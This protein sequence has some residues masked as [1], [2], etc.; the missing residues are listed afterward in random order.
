MNRSESR[1]LDGHR[2][3]RC[4]N[5]GNSGESTEYSG[6]RW[7]TTQTFGAI[8]SRVWSWWF[9]IIAFKS[10]KALQSAGSWSNRK[11]VSVHFCRT[12]RHRPL[13]PSTVLPSFF[14]SIHAI[15][16][17][18]DRI[19]VC[20]IAG[21]PA[22]GT[23]G[24]VSQTHEDSASL[25]EICD[26]HLFRIVARMG[27][28]R[29]TSIRLDCLKTKPAN[30]TQYCSS[31]FRHLTGHPFQ[32]WI[33]SITLLWNCH[34]TDEN[35]PGHTLTGIMEWRTLELQTFRR[36]LLI[37]SRCIVQLQF[38]IVDRNSPSWNSKSIQI[39]AITTEIPSI[40][41]IESKINPMMSVSIDITLSKVSNIYRQSIEKFHFQM[42]LILPNYVPVSFWMSQLFHCNLPSS[43]KFMKY[44]VSHGVL[45]SR[46]VTRM[47]QN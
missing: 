2:L 38:D 45:A 1:R 18:A 11:P 39:S 28:W 5:R 47:K 22:A 42:A 46:P 37:I 36:G 6:S 33:H 35:R 44:R 34:L 7:N 13:C 14:H 27:L 32:I 40:L 15:G 31:H 12:K 16:Q 4:G 26:W 23:V 25:Y 43:V 17:I 41:Q 10:E 20:V 24:P 8:N 19:G 3:L 9:L 30:R 29:E 21:A